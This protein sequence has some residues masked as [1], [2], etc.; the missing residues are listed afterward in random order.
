MNMIKR[1]GRIMTALK[2]D[3]PSVRNVWILIA[4]LAFAVLG[5]FIFIKLIILLD[6]KDYLGM[7]IPLLPIFYTI[8]YPIL[9]SPFSNTGQ[10][11]GRESVPAP[12]QIASPSYFMNLSFWRITG[13]IVIS[14]GI[15]FLMEFSQYAVLL[16]L[17][18]ESLTDIW[19]RVDPFLLLRLLK[20]DL[21]HS[22]LFMLFLEMILMGCMG[23]IWLGYTSKSRPIME[24][25]VAGT[26]LSGMIAFTNLTPLYGQIN[27]VTSQWVG[28]TGSKLHLE[29]FSGVLVFTF[30]FSCWVLVGLKLKGRPVN[31]RKS[32]RRK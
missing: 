31:A 16:F 12:I 7:V 4:T 5:A 30:L 14:L 17:S 6:L 26:L 27:Q 24:G 19:M 3:V 21:V 1:S 20:G 13:A 8:I 11:R 2:E 32:V 18:D 22:H 10:K 23:G 15:K 9:D 29:L 25:I 28:L